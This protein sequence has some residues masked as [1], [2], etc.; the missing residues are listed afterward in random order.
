MSKLA[1][2]SVKNDY[3]ATCNHYRKLAYPLFLTFFVLLL[4]SPV[5][6]KSAAVIINKIDL[7]SV[8]DFDIGRA[9]ADIW[10]LNKEAKIFLLSAKTGRGMT[11]WYDW[12]LKNANV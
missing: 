8:V 2:V 6:A 4:T 11:D 12:L 10:K 7:L 1:E 9:K 5:Q 3:R